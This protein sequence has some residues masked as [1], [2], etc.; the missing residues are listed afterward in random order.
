MSSEKQE[1]AQKKFFI[2]TVGGGK[3][4]TNTPNGVLDCLPSPSDTQ[5]WTIEAS[6]DDANVVAFKSCSSGQYLRN[7]I[8]QVL[9]GAKIGL[10]EKQWWTLER[11]NIPGS[12]AIRS[13]VC[14]VG[15]S[16][17]NDYE[18]VYRDNNLVH[19]WQWVPH[20]EFWLTW[21]LID[22]DNAANFNPIGEVAGKSATDAAASEK[23]ASEVE[24]KAK[25]LEAKEAAL[26]KKTDE[27]EK[28]AKA[29]EAQV[30]DVKRRE[31]AVAQREA[32]SSKSSKEPQ[33]AKK[34]NSPAPKSSPQ[35]DNNEDKHTIAMLRGEIER[36]KLRNE[37]GDLKLQLRNKDLEVQLEKAQ[38][39][40]FTGS[41]APRP[42]KAI[43]YGCGHKAYPP[44]RKIERRIVGIMYEGLEYH[45]LDQ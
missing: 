31:E 17:L 33:A 20:L 43:M 24:Q 32:A 2:V 39:A 16:Y 28:K 7:E 19:M 12:C 8:P 38:R 4:L 30:A 18:G 23:K 41:R 22:S 10:G 9:S 26:K 14:S 21:Y 1:Q 29:A 3:C 6:E 35:K 44:P 15:K 25:D 34:E 37:N 45:S 27:L 40:A 5:Y 13:N 11:G 36:L 42:S